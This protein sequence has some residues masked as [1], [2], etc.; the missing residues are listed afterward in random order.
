MQSRGKTKENTKQAGV[1]LAWASTCPPI[2]FL[3]LA[4][5][6]MEEAPEERQA[7]HVLSS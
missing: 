5:A 2:G 4:P 6:N 1:L 3:S 7:L